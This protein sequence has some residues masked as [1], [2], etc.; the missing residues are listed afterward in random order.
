MR[1]NEGRTLLNLMADTLIETL[2]KIFF[3][4][5]LL[6]KVYVI[7]FSLFLYYSLLKIM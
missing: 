5:T 7:L 3:N 6:R 4:L 2:S 1:T